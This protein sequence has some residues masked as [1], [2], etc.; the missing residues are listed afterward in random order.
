MAGILED[1]GHDVIEARDGQEALHVVQNDSPDVV[2]LDIWIPGIDGMQTLKAIKRLDPGCSVIM[3]SGHGTIETAVKAIKLGATDY[4]EKPLNLEDV[5]H[6]VQRAIANREAPGGGKFLNGGTPGLL[7]GRSD[8]A[9][10][11]RRSLENAA[12]ESG[13]VWIAGEKGA[14]KEFA[15]RVIHHLSGGDRSNLVK[16][17]SQ[18]ISELNI[19]EVFLGRNGHEAS[20]KG[21]KLSQAQGGTLL[22]TGLDRLEAGGLA[23]LSET[24]HEFTESRGPGSFRIFVTADYDPE[25]LVKSKLLPTDLAALLGNRVIRVPSLRERPDDI[26]LF[27]DHFLNEA[28]AE[29]DRNILGADSAAMEKLVAYPWPGNVKEL[30]I[31]IEHVVMTAP[32][33]RITVR[34]LLIPSYETTA[35]AP[36]ASSIQVRHA[37][38][39]PASPSAMA[40]D[41][42]LS[43]ETVEAGGSVR[44]Q[45]TLRTSAV[46]YGQGL[47]SGVKT[48]LTLSPLPPGSGIL[49]GQLA[50]GGTVSA[51][52]SCVDSTEQ[53]TC[54]SANGTSVRTVEHL[55]AVLHVYGLTN[56]LVKISGEVP[57][58]DGSAVEFCDL[59]ESAEIINQDGAVEE[60]RVTEP[61]ELTFPQ[62][63][64]KRMRVEPSDRFEIDYLLDYPPPIGRMRM[65][66]VCEDPEDFKREIAPAR[67]F[68]FVKDMRMMDEKGLAGG[69]RLSNVILL[70]DE[71]VVNPPLRFPDEF[72][73]H[74]ILDLIGDFYLLGRPFRGKVS[75]S[76]TGHSDNVAMLR[77]IEAKLMTA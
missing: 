67:T 6:L 59:L 73:R 48:G 42:A 23:A 17:R 12:A 69:G 49:F 27:V 21:G 1:E 33:P 37:N 14:G 66:Y 28:M 18:D 25:T 45:K 30:K 75:A 44:R 54:L 41:V 2:F 24:L 68:G 43:G 19:R 31:M 32:G 38:S 58:M 36:G 11:L 35:G 57:I 3:M 62:E 74:K 76:Q 64:A 9:A 34:D 13:S 70:D 50:A 20:P 61:L 8:K 55:M 60:I 46:M 7:I 71:K 39:R 56:L 52:L 4:L 47:H 63:S 15:A 16:A 5:L 51:L 22:I 26:P 40:G 10:R 29:F 77:L 72:V 65:S 53:A